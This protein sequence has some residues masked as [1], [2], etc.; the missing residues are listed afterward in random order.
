MRNVPPKG[1]TT[2]VF[3]FP[4]MAMVR[5]ERRK[6]GVIPFC[7]GTLLNTRYVLS[8]AGCMSKLKTVQV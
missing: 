3:E 8:V 5:F 2:S 7:L 4:W 6:N 1:Q